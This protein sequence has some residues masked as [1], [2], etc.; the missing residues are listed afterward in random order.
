[1]AD[2]ADKPLDPIGAVVAEWIANDSL[3]K[4]ASTGIIAMVGKDH[5][6]CRKEVCTNYKALLPIVTHFGS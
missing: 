4:Q 1:M 3:V 5:E 2:Q 6:I